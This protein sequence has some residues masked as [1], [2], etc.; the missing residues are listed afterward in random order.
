MS[1]SSLDY[2]VTYTFSGA[3]RVFPYSFRVLSPTDLK[4]TVNGT[5]LTIG[6]HY[7]VGNEFYYEGGTVTIN[8]SY[9][10]TNNQI[11]TI[12]RV[13][14]S[15]TQNTIFRNQGAFYAD[16]V[17]EAFD[18]LT[19]L[20]Q[21]LRQ[22][23]LLLPSY[24]VT[25]SNVDFTFP[26][27]IDGRYLQWA[28]RTV[29]G[30]PQLFLQNA[31]LSADEVV[32]GTLAIARGGTGSSSA[33]GAWTNIGL[34]AVGTAQPAAL[35]TAALAGI[36]NGWARID[37]VHRYPTLTELGAASRGANTDI[38]SIA[39]TSG[40]ITAI[41][42]NA[43]SIVNKDYVDSVARN[44]N[45]HT[46]VIA[47]TTADLGTVQ[48]VH[49]GM[50][51][52][53]ATLTKTTTFAA[54]T[55]DGI[56][57][58]VGQRV[59]VKNQITALQNGVYTV[60]NVGSP[61]TAWVLTR[62]TDYDSIG[63]GPDQIDQGD[64][65]LVISGTLNATTTWVLQNTP[66]ILGT[67]PLTFIQL[68]AGANI[69]TAGTGLTVA[70]NQF[71]VTNVPI[72]NGGSGQTSAQ[73]ALNAFAGAVTAGRYLRGDGTNVTM[74]QLAAA[75]VT[76][77]LTSAQ[78]AGVGITQVG[79][80]GSGVST[81]LQNPT[82][83]NL[84]SAVT[85]ETGSGN[86]VFNGS[87]TLYDPLFYAFTEASIVVNAVSGTN[88]ISGS[89]TLHIC[90]LPSTGV[91]CTFSLPT[92][93]AG[94]SLILFIRQPATINASTAVISNVRWAGGVAPTFTST[95]GRQDIVSLF[96]DGVFWYGSVTLNYAY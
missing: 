94:K 93:T 91:T 64:Q 49:Y 47:A 26:T 16:T 59:L 83:T 74:S 43:T 86:L 37:H 30:Q 80:L 54:F 40:S 65:F 50:T 57:P 9:P 21:E 96:S 71:S 60:T 17:E 28:T 19:M 36:S 13:M 85:G 87:P 10:L 82:S 29:S 15:Y 2:T 41:P 79:A 4:V 90:Q 22:K 12:S 25:N 55:I 6:T 77:T 70:A 46:A 66:A 52:V 81:F 95:I 1:V 48:Y 32:L 61:S 5:T 7:T 62:A 8:N 27:P 68:G 56:S 92:P 58:I 89:Y 24:P 42:N 33:A 34:P 84:L 72:A 14:S 31:V 63:V 39:L 51:G 73:A 3:T 11:I 23:V 44:I 75:D 38:T 78:I 76:G 69:Y 53:G 67:N 88:F 18:K 20:S 45:F 35:G